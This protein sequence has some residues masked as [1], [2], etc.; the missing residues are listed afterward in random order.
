[1]NRKG[2][3]IRDDPS[4]SVCRA[5]RVFASFL[6]G[7]DERTRTRWQTSGSGPNTLHMCAI[8]TRIYVVPRPRHGSLLAARLLPDS[9]PGGHDMW[10]LQPLNYL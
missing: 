2:V 5:V 7:G 4:K 9:L 10:C 6:I 8:M 1:M 3:E